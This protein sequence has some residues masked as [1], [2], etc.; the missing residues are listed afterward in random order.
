M[1]TRP[2][3]PGL[4]VTLAV[5][6]AGCGGN[7]PTSQLASARRYP[8]KG[9]VLLP[10]GK[11]LSSTRLIF[12]STT[13]SLTAPTET[14][15]DGTF[16]IKGDPE[17]L[18]EGE[19]KVYL[20]VLETKGTLKHPVLPFPGKYRDE[21]NSDLK[22]TVKPEPNDFQLKLNNDNPEPTTKAMPKTR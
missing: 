19:Y 11:P 18:P 16:A 14:D 7:N 21:D 6:A 17:G 22:V 13:T 9:K 15:S 4:A 1:A 12:T 10:D 2:D 5:F 8:V 20:E 3:R